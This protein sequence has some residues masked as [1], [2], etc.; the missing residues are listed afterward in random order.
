MSRRR[1]A[2]SDGARRDAAKT[3]GGGAG[4][5]TG[6]RIGEII[7]AAAQSRGARRLNRRSATF[8]TINRT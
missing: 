8:Q 1:A 7:T 6:G 3:L 5:F 2:L 4:V